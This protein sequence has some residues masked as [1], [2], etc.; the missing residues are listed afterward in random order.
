MGVTDQVGKQNECKKLL[1]GFLLKKKDIKPVPIQSHALVEKKYASNKQNT[2][3]KL[4]GFL[5]NKQKTTT[6]TV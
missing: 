2:T 3:N 4:E 1:C 6:M 5:I